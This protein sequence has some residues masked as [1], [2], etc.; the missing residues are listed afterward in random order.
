MA[1]VPRSMFGT[2]VDEDT[3]KYDI[4]GGSCWLTANG[5]QYFFWFTVD[6]GQAVQ[7]LDCETGEPLGGC[8]SY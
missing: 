7:Y 1:D 4:G 2:R 5:K 6:S 8:T 3:I